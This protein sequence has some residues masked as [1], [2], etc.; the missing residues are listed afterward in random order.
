MEFVFFLLFL[1]KTAVWCFEC[2]SSQDMI[3]FSK[4]CGLLGSKKR[5]SNIITDIYEKHE[6]LLH[7][8][9]ISKDHWVTE[10]F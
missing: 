9:K 3:I 10:V 1:L 8:C 7:L 4:D 2:I 6:I 5:G